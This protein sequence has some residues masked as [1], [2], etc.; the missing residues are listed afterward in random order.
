VVPAKCWKVVVVVDGSRGDDLQK[1][2][3]N[4]RLIAVIMPNDMT[5]GEQWAGFRVSVHDIEQLTGYRFFTQVPAA[6]IEPMKDE[7][8]AEPIPAPAAL[9]H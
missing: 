8:D 4:T 2:D 5:V 3:A 6:V 7:V 9:T 1:V